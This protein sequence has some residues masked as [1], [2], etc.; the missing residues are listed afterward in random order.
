[1]LLILRRGRRRAK[2]ESITSR[3]VWPRTSVTTILAA[4]RQEQLP[5]VQTPMKTTGQGRGSVTTLHR[6]TPQ[7]PTVTERT[8]A[9]AAELHGRGNVLLCGQLPHNSRME[10]RSNTLAGDRSARILGGESLE[11]EP[12]SGDS[13]HPAGETQPR[14]SRDEIDAFIIN[15][16]T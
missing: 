4:Q 3:C 2:L 8:A 1:M 5:A 10:E 16:I 7:Q 11:N 12:H 13:D 9:N 6:K 15:F 14:P